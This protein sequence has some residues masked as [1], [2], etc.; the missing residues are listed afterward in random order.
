MAHLA[1]GL[2]HKVWLLL[3]AIPYW[4][5][6]LNKDSTFWY[7]SIKIFRQKEKNNWYEVMERVS[8]EL[9]KEFM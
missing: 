9:K 7:P 3:K 1:A 8:I 5:W 4:T 6:G 2:G